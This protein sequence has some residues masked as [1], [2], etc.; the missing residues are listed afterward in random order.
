MMVSMA[1]MKSLFSFI[2]YDLQRECSASNGMTEEETI[3]NAM[4]RLQSIN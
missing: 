1:W 2:G 3:L 4:R